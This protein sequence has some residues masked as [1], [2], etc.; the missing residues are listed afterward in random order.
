MKY[1]SDLNMAATN[2]KSPVDSK[3]LKGNFSK[4]TLRYLQV[5]RKKRK[6]YK[7]LEI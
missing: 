5:L 2:N 3:S 4:K 6:T 1:C 7:I